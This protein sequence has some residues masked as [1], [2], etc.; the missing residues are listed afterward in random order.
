MRESS[1]SSLFPPLSEREAMS[2]LTIRT[3]LE[4]VTGG[5]LSGGA[6]ALVV[7]SEHLSVITTLIAILT[8][9]VVITIWLARLQ[10]DMDATQKEMARHDV[11][12]K[13]ALERI[14]HELTDLTTSLPCRQPVG[15]TWQR[16]TT[17]R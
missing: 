7:T 9:V 13:T 16:P 8:P 10:K 2:H 14:H 11:E 4:L 12:V 1:S 15:G 6:I 5:G 3:W 17:A